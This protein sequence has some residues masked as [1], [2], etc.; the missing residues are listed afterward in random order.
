MA[1][2]KISRQNLSRFRKTRERKERNR[3]MRVG[4]RILRPNDA[5]APF[6]RVVNIVPIVP[7]VPS[8]KRASHRK[9]VSLAGVRTLGRIKCMYICTSTLL[10][11]SCVRPPREFAGGVS[12]DPTQNPL[13]MFNSTASP[14]GCGD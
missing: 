11:M 2:L 5:D 1:I 14:S 10:Y 12:I 9:L 6:L 7:H 4:S 13:H 3:A 8:V